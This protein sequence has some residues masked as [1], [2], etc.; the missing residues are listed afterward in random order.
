[1]L[2]NVFQKWAA[3]KKVKQCFD[4]YKYQAVDKTL[5]KEECH[6]Q[7]IAWSLIKFRITFT[8]FSIFSK[9]P[10]SLCNSFNFEKNW[11]HLNVK[12][13]LNFTDLAPCNY[14]KI[15]IIVGWGQLLSLIILVSLHISGLLLQSLPS[16]WFA[17]LL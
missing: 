3:A 16:I 1:M 2:L 5:C 8:C 17:S 15:L 13:I 10:L 6:K 14:L 12:I 9:L 7:I 11:K 4:E